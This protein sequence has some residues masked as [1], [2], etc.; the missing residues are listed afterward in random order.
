MSALC[1]RVVKDWDGTALNYESFYEAGEK[2]QFELDRMI[3]EGWQ[4]A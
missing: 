4:N 3:N 1:G 2:A